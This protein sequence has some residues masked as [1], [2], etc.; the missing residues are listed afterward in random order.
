MDLLE[1]VQMSA[2][3]MI[4]GLKRLFFEGRLGEMGLVNLEKEKA[5]GR[6]DCGLS[7]LEGALQKRWGQTLEHGLLQ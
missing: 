6:P 1:G 2:T 3:K 7:V 5:P 4:R